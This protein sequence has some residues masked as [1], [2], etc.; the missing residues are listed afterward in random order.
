M[1][2]PRTNQGNKPAYYIMC[3][4]KP[5]S[6]RFV[7]VHLDGESDLTSCPHDCTLFSSQTTALNKLK[8]LQHQLPNFDWY[9]C[10]TRTHRPNEY[11]G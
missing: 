7:H 2:L 11:V 9:L 4:S 6:F 10:T 3:F 1:S 5:A 8:V